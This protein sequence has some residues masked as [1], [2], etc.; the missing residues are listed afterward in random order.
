MRATLTKN[1]FRRPQA[2]NAVDGHGFLD[3]GSVIEIIETLTGVSVDG[4]N[5]WHKASDGFFYWGGGVEY[6]EIILESEPN[7]RRLNLLGIA[8]V[9]K[10][11]KGNFVNIAIL[12]DSGDFR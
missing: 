10:K 4:N 12:Q 2:T 7:A 5:T 6:N 8:G 3:K 11:S 9:W 1:L